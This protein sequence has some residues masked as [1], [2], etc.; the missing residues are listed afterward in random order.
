MVE[1]Q[2]TFN[3]SSLKPFPSGEQ[4]AKKDSSKSDT[5]TRTQVLVFCLHLIKWQPGGKAQ[6]PLSPNARTL[7][8]GVCHTFACLNAGIKDQLASPTDVGVPAARQLS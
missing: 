6:N 4:E 1:P 7:L 5:E 3:D 8:S 2:L